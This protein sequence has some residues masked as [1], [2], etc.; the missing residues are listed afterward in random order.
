M[1]FRFNSGRINTARLQQVTIYKFTKYKISR[2]FRLYRHALFDEVIAQLQYGYN[3]KLPY[4]F[5]I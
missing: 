5:Q 1:L 3:R 4:V 2:Q